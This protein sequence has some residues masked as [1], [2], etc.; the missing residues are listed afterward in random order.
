MFN[1]R[2][3]ILFIV[4][5]L[6]LLTKTP[7][8]AQTDIPP[9]GTPKGREGE[10]TGTIINR[11]PG[12]S[13]PESVDV[14]LHSW[15]QNFTEKGMLHG[16][17]TAD[18][19]FQFTEVSLEP[20]LL[21]AVMAI[22]D[23]VT[24]FSESM[25]VGAEDTSLD[26]E[27]PIYDTS[28]DLSQVQAD[29]VHV[30][31]LFAQGGLEVIEV[32]ILSNQGEYTVKDAVLLDDGLPATY[33]FALPEN[34]ANVSFNTEDNNRFVQFPGGF[35]D[36]APHVPGNDSNQIS[37]SY[38]LP[39]K[40]ELSYNFTSP[41]FTSSVKFLVYQDPGI[42]VEGDGI[43]FD[44]VQTMQDSMTL[45]VYSHDSLEPNETVRISITGKPTISTSLVGSEGQESLASRASNVEIG[46]GV[47]GLGLAFIAVGVWWWR[48]N[49]IGDSNDVEDLL[50][51][52]G[53]QDL[54][55]KIVELNETYSKGSITKKEYDQRHTALIHQG[56]V[57]LMEEISPL[58][59]QE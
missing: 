55:E 27:V 42:N 2:P 53:Y 23:G 15:D 14:M 5:I 30:L 24:Y 59:D 56:K 18:A 45:E 10:V 35:A 4:S 51:L 22:Y 29:N 9:E 40:D 19:S 28:T 34:A 1:T 50:D 7:A 6:I 48:K 32:Y 13:I 17:S 47:F 8:S 33:K 49:T 57:L 36:T 52:P 21:Y 20:N 37:V 58:S 39:Y 43:V 41:L 44:G 25:Q 12:G 3:L 46:I 16:Q 11:S 38:V 54:L 26:I 31:F